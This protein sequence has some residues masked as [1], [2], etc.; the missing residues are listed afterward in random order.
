MKIL[1]TGSSGFIGNILSQYLEH[2][3]SIIRHGRQGVIAS[4]DN[5]CR[6]NINNNSNWEQC[7]QNVN[8]IVHLAAVAHNKSNDPDYINEVNVKGTI[9]LA[10]QAVKMGVKRFVFISSI[11]VLGNDTN[12]A[13][14]FD[15]HSNVL[16]HS[17]YAQSKLDAEN[18][19]LK[20]AEE[21]DL[22]VIII[23][24]VLVYGKGAPGNF[25]KL[26]SLV[27]KVPILPFA[28]CDNKRSFISV[29]N[30]ADFISVCL[31]HP[32]A[33]NEVFCISDGVDVSIKEFTNEIA[34]GL[35]TG[36]L[37]VPIPNYI[38]NLI[39]KITSRKAQIDQLIGDL[40]VNTNKAKT[41]LDW[42][43]PFTMADTLSRLTRKI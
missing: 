9:N 40:Q 28:L 7:L 29:D 6:V 39:G 12:N 26:A 24:P 17:E 41:L 20:I 34:K 2:K 14:P 4:A 3:H 31:E 8:A 21:T 42:T 18:A 19:L 11:G 23:R 27:N 22:E 10:Q 36:L 38:F 15:E 16:P 25:D 1:V 37:Q 13:K 32:K 5:L 30:L 35:H 33:K 43:P